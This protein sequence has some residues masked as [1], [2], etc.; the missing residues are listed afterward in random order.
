MSGEQTKVGD[1]LVVEEERGDQL[2]SWA[3]PTGGRYSSFKADIKAEKEAA[4]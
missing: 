1:C 4:R 2:G 3:A